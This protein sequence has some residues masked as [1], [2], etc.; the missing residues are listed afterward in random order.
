MSV[1]IEWRKI[2]HKRLFSLS[3]SL[4]LSLSHTHAISS[5]LTY[6][7]FDLHYLSNTLFH[8][9]HSSLI[10]THTH[11]HTHTQTLTLFHTISRAN[12]AILQLLLHRRLLHSFLILSNSSEK[13]HLYTYTIRSSLSSSLIIHNIASLSANLPHTH[14]H[15]HECQSISFPRKKIFFSKKR[16]IS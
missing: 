12:E 13:Y 16:K 2:L 1:H 7:L 8:S 5:S 3:L 6:T 4:P 9:H 11:T 10:H 15:T 14:T